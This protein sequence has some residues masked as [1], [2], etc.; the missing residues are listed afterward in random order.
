LQ[1]RRTAAPAGLSAAPQALSRRNPM[2]ERTQ[3]QQL[4]PEP[5]PDAQVDAKLSGAPGFAVKGLFILALFYTF[6]FARSLLL[7]IVLALLLSLIL[8]PAVRALKRM[9][10]PEPVGAAAVVAGLTAVLVWGLVQLFEPASDWLAKMPKIAEQVERKLSTV[11]KSMEH[12]TNAAAKVEELTTVEAETKRP[13]QVIARPPS[14]VSRVL[15]GTQNVVIA[16]GATA[17]LLFF[18]L[19]S[20]DLFMRKLVRVLPTLEDKKKAVAVARTIQSAIAQYLFTITCIN[21]GLGVAT[22]AVLHLLGMPN[23]ILWGVMV[24]LFNYVPYIGPAVS[25]TVLTV[26]AFL[27]FEHMNDVLLVPAAYFALETIEGQFITPIL[28]GR[29]LTLN[30][31]MIF[32]SMLLWG[33]IWGVIGALMAVPILMTLKIF[34]DHVESLH[35]LGEFLTGK[36]SKPL[37][38]S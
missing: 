12:V 21:V 35:T 25:G 32:L 5:A 29:S 9:L 31:V 13:A 23:A 30:P 24:A 2:N 38:E 34:C 1:Q 14:L 22:A 7:P 19:A 4:I 15:S 17:V 26:V 3:L 33:W 27:T 11:R 16:A 36:S 20:G 37:E 18:I 8:S 10:I 28:T 6:Y